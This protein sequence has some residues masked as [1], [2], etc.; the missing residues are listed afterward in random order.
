[1]R[2]PGEDL[3]QEH[4]EQLKEVGRGVE[5]SEPPGYDLKDF[6]AEEHWRQV[7]EERVPQAVQYPGISVFADDAGTGKTTNTDWGLQLLRRDYAMLFPTQKKAFEHAEEMEELHGQRP[8][9]LKG[10]HQPLYRACMEAKFNDEPCPMHGRANECPTMCPS[11]GDE[12]DDEELMNVMST[13]GEA[14]HDEVCEAGEDCPW[15]LQF[16]G[17]HNENYIVGVHQYQTHPLLQDH[18]IVVDEANQGM[19]TERIITTDELMD[20]KIKIENEVHYPSA[21]GE[22]QKVVDFIDD[23]VHVLRD[24]EL[25]WND[26]DLPDLVE[27]PTRDPARTLADIKIE[28]NETIAAD[29]GLGM[30]DGTQPYLDAVIGAM[31]EISHDPEPYRKAVSAPQTLFVCPACGDESGMYE[32]DGREC[33]ECGW[34]RRD[35]LLDQE[36]AR[37]MVGEYNKTLRVDRL[38][39]TSEL[40]SDPILLDATVTDGSVSRFYGVHQSRDVRKFG[41]ETFELNGEVKQVVSGN[42]FCGQ[43]KGAFSSE[44]NNWDQRFQSVVDSL[45]RKHHDEGVLFVSTQG[46][47]DHL[48]IPQEA[49]TLPYWGSRGLSRRGCDVA[50]LLGG[51]YWNIDALRERAHLLDIGYDHPGFSVGG[52]EKSVRK[53]RERERKG[54]PEERVKDRLPE[55]RRKYMF[56]DQWGYGRSTYVTEYTGLVGD[57]HEERCQKEIEQM[58]HRVRPIPAEREKTIYIVTKVPTE[59]PVDTIIEMDDLI[60]D[61]FRDAVDLTPRAIEFLR[62]WVDEDCG[63]TTQEISEEVDVHRNTVGRWVDVLRDRDLIEEEYIFREGKKFVLKEPGIHQFLHT[64]ERNPL[65]EN[66]E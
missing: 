26:L 61:R 8:R 27:S 43:I 60:D 56:R 33:S 46:V 64:W 65:E 49:E 2:E 39:L 54:Y 25:T 5:I 50:I 52:I 6:N 28:L 44:E 31:A 47:L 22:K 10:K 12:G 16:N 17:I 58:V 20:M 30:W 35:N 66:Y 41:E 4:K 29:I 24:T 32:S 59:V 13:L 38:P 18:Q 21:T 57:L 19:G 40:P 63:Y 37:I 9:H 11:V 48:D 51:P 7:R 15:L 62:A 42:Y 1:M 53:S 55:S 3:T 14:A 36:E 34:H 23:L 45:W